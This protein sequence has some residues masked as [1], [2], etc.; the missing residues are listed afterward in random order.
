M[1]ALWTT[2]F[3]K[4]TARASNPSVHTPPVPDCT[5]LRKGLD[6][7]GQLRDRRSGPYATRVAG[8]PRDRAPALVRHSS[9]PRLA[10]LPG[11]SR[12]SAGRGGRPAVRAEADV[13]W[14]DV[15]S[16]VV[17]SR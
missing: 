15:L 3:R 8:A 11:R 14:P 6:R 2:P 12:N 16:R 17:Q 13:P 1:S 7:A 4:K 10:V 5:V 9:D